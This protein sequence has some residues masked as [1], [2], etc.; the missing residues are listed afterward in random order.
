MTVLSLQDRILILALGIIGKYLIQLINETKRKKLFVTKTL[1]HFFKETTE[2][3]F[4]SEK[5]QISNYI[6]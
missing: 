1:I 2:K 6:S 3:I 5:E 4:N